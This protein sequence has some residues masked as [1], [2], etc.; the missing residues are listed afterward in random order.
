MTH[1]YASSDDFRQ[2]IKYIYSKY[3][4]ENENKPKQLFL[5]A[6]SMGANCIMKY[7]GEDGEKVPITAVAVIE[8]PL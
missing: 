5:I 6:N 2:P 3:C 7:L 4:L 1:D 8:V